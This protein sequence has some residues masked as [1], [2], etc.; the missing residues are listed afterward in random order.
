MTRDIKSNL[1]LLIIEK[2]KVLGASLAGIAKVEELKKSPSHFIYGKLDEYRGLGT[3]QTDRT[4]PK[5]VVW[6]ENSMSTVVIG[7]AHPE[8]EPE[9]DWWQDG[10][11][12]GTPG[13]QILISISDKLSAWLE[14]EKR[15]KTKKLPYNIEHGGIFLKDGAVTAGL[16]CIGKNNLIVTPEFGPR[17]RLRALLIDAVLPSTG[18]LDFD[19]CEQ[20]SMPCRT[21]CPQDAF[22]RKVYSE[23]QFGLTELPART[24]VYSRDMCNVQMKLDMANSEELRVRGRLES[25]RLIRYC[26]RC[27]LVCPV[28]KVDQ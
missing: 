5:D 22:G 1:T 20:C 21:V 14:N 12:G 11:R 16:G 25:K 9:L 28:G 15:I 24:G 27:E 4:I 10:Y 8:A 2:A 26:R 23:Q 17:V 13:N 3:K 19:P 18:P 6:P 7:V